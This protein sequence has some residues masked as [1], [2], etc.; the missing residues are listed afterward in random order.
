MAVIREDNGDARADNSTQYSI[1]PGDVFHGTLDT[2]GDTDWIKVE[3]SAGRIYDIRLDGLE[4]DQFRLF[5]P[6]GGN[7]IYGP[8][9]LS[10]STLYRAPDS[11]TYHIAIA[12]TN[13]SDSDNYEISFLEH[14]LSAASYDEIAGY[15]KRSPEDNYIYDVEPGGTLTANITALTEDGQQLA[16]WALEAWT[17]VTGIKFEFVDN[18]ANISFDDDDLGSAYS[19]YTAVGGIKVSSYINVGEDWLTTYGSGIDSFTFYAYLHEIGHA[20]GLHHP[21][22]YEGLFPDSIDKIF[23][24]D[25]YQTTVM[26]YFRQ[27]SDN[28]TDASFAI[29]VTPMIADIIAIQ[30]LYGVPVDINPGNTLH[31]HGSDVEGYMAELFESWTGQGDSSFDNPVTLTLFDSGGIDTLDLSTDVSDQ[32][33]DLRPEGISD[34]YGLVGNLIIARDTLIENFIAGSG[35]DV[36]TGNDEANYLQGGDGNDELQGNGGNDVLEGGA[37]A[38]R[39]EGGAGMDWVSYQTSNAAVTINLAQGT[40]RGG[41]AEGDVII[42]IENVIGS[43]YGDVLEGDSGDN[44]L[45]G[46]PG[47]DE[48]SGNDGNDVLEG[49]AGADRLSGG[50]GEDTASYEHSDAA[51]TV[52]L[53]SSVVQGGDAE[54]DTFGAMVTVGYTDRNGEAQQETVPDIEHLRGSGYDD[55]LAGDSRAN[56]LEGG[57]GAD[58]LYGGPG[59][60]DDVLSGGPGEDALFGGIGDDLLW[61]GPGADTLRGGAGTDTASYAQSDAGVTV[62]LHDGTVQGGHAE[63]DDIADIENVRG[64]AHADILEGDEGANRLEGSGGADELRGN[65]GDDALEGGGGDDVLEGGGGADRLDGGTGVDWLSYAGSDGPVSV[66]LYDGYAA[67]GHAEGDTISGFENLRGS[68]YADALAGNGRANRLEGGAGNDR[69]RGG[70]G[71]D[72][73]HGGAGADRLNGGPGTDTVVYWTSDAAITINLGEGTGMG[74]H[75]EGDTIAEV[76]NVEGSDH[77]D[78]LEGDGGINRLKGGAG[79][80]NLRG[81]GGDDVLDGGA[82]ADRLD[83]GDGMDT[84]FYGASNEAITIDLSD[85]TATG[86]HAQGDVLADIEIISG[87]AYGDMLIGSSGADRFDSDDGD[88]ILEGGAGADRLDGG[89]G[90]DTAIYRNSNAAV[91][92]NLNTDT[93]AGG[94]AEGDELFNIENIEGSDYDDVL[95]GDNG[96]NRLEGGNGDDL[97]EGREGSDLLDGGPGIDTVSYENSTQS[98]QVSLVFNN[99]VPSSIHDIDEIINIENVIGSD[100]GDTLRGDIGDNEIYGGWGN[101][102]IN[103]LAGDDRLFGEAGDDELWGQAGADELHGGGGVDTAVYWFSEEAVTVNLKDGTAQGGDAEGDVLVGIENLWGSEHDDVLIGDDGANRLSGEF[104]NNEFYGNGGDDV[105]VSGADADLLDGGAGMDTVSY[106]WSNEGVMVNLGDGIVEGGHAEGDILVDIENIEG[107]FHDDVLVGNNMVNQLSG[108]S[109]N[110]ELEGGEGADHFIFSS[111]NKNDTI[112][113]FTDNEDL[114]DLTGF[115][116]ISG[117]DDLTITSDSDGVTIDLTAYRGGTILLEGFDIANLDASDFIF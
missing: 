24:N 105:L 86:G 28:F 31:G 7:V 83:G 39:H 43:D 46:G 90:S 82:G 61:G 42:D 68:A 116:N 40:L 47:N 32:R 77:N 30:D 79:D 14:P 72:I 104:G 99:A 63:G 81:A 92:V 73:L 9:L 53:H 23:G 74:G 80:D 11:G 108:G 107:S 102:I 56:R 45:R 71:D 101:D 16:R 26:S 13:Y 89:P 19:S 62:R 106:N 115:R 113:D 38:D 15:L 44:W 48:I 3:L 59:G 100:Y 64:S 8:Y 98:V 57:A 54:D 70:S 2:A 58:R 97:L 96:P 18:N 50:A 49:S 117:F 22:P 88:D 36:V 94:H 17:S 95:T 78:V 91:T 5:N 4:S 29:P 85:G 37:G 35:D 52:R 1:A 25:S 76:E 10:Y 109:G 114:I 87:S 65:G 27:D 60:G 33:V 110:D 12:R 69:M 111:A 55:L 51:V 6:N 103:G 112:L 75:A 66:R 20:L 34:V 67:R 93:L 21:G 41:H 84:A